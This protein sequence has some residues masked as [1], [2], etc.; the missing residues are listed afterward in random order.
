MGG[1]VA[2]CDAFVDAP[3]DD[4]EEDAIDVDATTF[5]C[6]FGAVGV[7]EAILFIA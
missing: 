5:E 1:N 7:V 6:A 2:A 3:N 4:T